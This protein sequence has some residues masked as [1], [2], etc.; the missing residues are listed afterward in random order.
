MCKL[1][2]YKLIREDFNTGKRGK[3]TKK[4]FSFEDN[5][6]VGGL[7]LNLGPGYPGFQRVLSVE[8]EEIP[9]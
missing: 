8:V 1:Y 5:L 3:R 9:D 7:Y 6:K 2:Q 4:L